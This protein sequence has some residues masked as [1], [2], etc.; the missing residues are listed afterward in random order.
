MLFRSINGLSEDSNFPLRV[1]IVL[2][3]Q[4][5]SMDL[6]GPLEIFNY[7]HNPS[8]ESISKSSYPSNPLFITTLAAEQ[9][10][11]YTAQKLGVQRD[12][13]FNEA[14]LRLKEW[15]IIV[16]PGGNVPAMI[17]TRGDEPMTLLRAFAELAEGEKCA[18]CGHGPAR[19][20][21]VFSVCTGSIFLAAAGLLEERTA[22]THWGSIDLLK[23]GKYGEVGKV[24]SERFVVNQRKKREGM[25]L[26]VITSGGISCGMDAALWLVGVV[27]DDGAREGVEKM[28]EYRGRSDEG[29]FM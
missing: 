15:D 28:I 18:S 16:V 12:I 11:T 27:G 20:R 24:V 21:T 1:L 10:V 9:P 17:D 8:S 2:H 7:A 25:S 4:M 6:A 22:T 29:L 14:H 23:S 26:A 19:L 13:T 3:P 5:D